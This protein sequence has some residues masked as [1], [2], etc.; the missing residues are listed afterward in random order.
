LTA[1]A[2][3]GAAITLSPIDPIKALYWSAVINGVV[4]VPV[5]VIL[6]LMTAQPRIVGKF[7]VTGGLRWLGWASTI[8]MAACVVGMV[9]GWFIPE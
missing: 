9:L 8:A 4:A 2:V 3:L 7:T 5:M 6:M 1:A